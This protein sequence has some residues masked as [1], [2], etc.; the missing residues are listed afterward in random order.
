MF[1]VPQPLE[2]LE[3]TL[4][5]GG[6]LIFTFGEDFLTTISKAQLPIF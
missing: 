6:G 2:A 4:V 3:L 1:W 5:G